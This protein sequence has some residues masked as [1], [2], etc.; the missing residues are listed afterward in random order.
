[1]DIKKIIDMYVEEN[2]STRAIA[3]TFSTYPNKIRRALVSS[4][5]E[6]RSKS[7]AQKEALKSGRHSH[8]TKGKPRPEEVK[9]KISISLEKAWSEVSDKERSR[10]SALAKK[11][12]ENMPEQEKIDLRKK[13]SEALFL[14][15]KEGSKPERFLYEKLQQAG[16]EVFLHKK[17]MIEGKKYEM[18]LF[19]PEISTIIEVDGPQHFEPVFGEK[20]LR[21]Y[22]KHDIIK[23]GILI[24]RGYCVVRIKYLCTT[25]TRAAGRRLWNLVEPVVHQIENKFPPQNKRLIELE[26]S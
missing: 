18:D 5:I 2:M 16:H 19:L 10:R 7:D 3:D 26:I 15:I 25:F 13:A 9:D 23:N 11:Q 22:V 14:T 8:P 6:L 1:M 21:E 4:G 12:W 17:D 20:T 24:R